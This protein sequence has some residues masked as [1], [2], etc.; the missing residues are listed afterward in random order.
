MLL[1]DWSDSMVQLRP[2]QLETWLKPL[3]DTAA[4]FDIEHHGFLSNHL[5]HN[6]VCLAATG[7]SKED[8]MW[9]QNHYLGKL[10]EPHPRHDD[11]PE[12]A[13][14]PIQT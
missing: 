5:T 10:E 8:A 7:A 12:P 13:L 11:G 4:Q 6:W 9:W 1:L 2:L 3:L 14:I